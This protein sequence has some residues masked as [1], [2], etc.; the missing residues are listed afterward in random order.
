M[1]AGV[2]PMILATAGPWTWKPHPEVWLLV[3]AIVAL[4]WWAVRVIGPKVVPA[5]QP[6]VTATQRR[7]FG[8]AVVLLLV[9][10]DWPMHDI[11]EDHLYSVHM[12][13]HLLI[14]FIVPPLFLLATP[15]W[16]VRLLVLEGDL[17]SRVLRRLTHPVVAGVI[18]NALA[19]LTHW[20]GIIRLSAESGGF[21]YAAHVTMFVSALLMWMPVASP[22]HELRLSPP[23]QMVY[24]FLMSVIPTIPAAWLTFADGT[25]YS[26]YDDGY[27][28]WSISVRSDQQ[29]AGLIMKLLGGGYLWTIIIVKFFAFSHQHRSTQQLRPAAGRQ[30]AGP[31]SVGGSVEPP[32]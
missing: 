3:V 19:A 18:F 16:L 24:L 31:N 30:P 14:T 13:Q 28:L 22:L 27:E 26:N 21:H 17:G 32:D 20:S 29:A 2:P 8:L 6:V 23:G 15:A 9:A 11:A 10:A 12:V 7:T 25:V 5:G 1:P 4:G